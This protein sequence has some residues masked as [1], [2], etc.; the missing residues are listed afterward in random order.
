MVGWVFFWTST[1]EGKGE[2]IDEGRLGE[3]S[4]MDGTEDRVIRGRGRLRSR[5][6]SDTA[7]GCQTLTIDT[8]GAA[9][10][11]QL[12]RQIEASST[13]TDREKEKCTYT[14]P[15]CRV[16]GQRKTDEIEE[17]EAYKMC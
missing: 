6:V 7:A 10:H 2:G 4:T 17:G 13:S 16:P 12:S 1:E 15:S 14:R 5:T 3:G 8:G 11:I 9:L